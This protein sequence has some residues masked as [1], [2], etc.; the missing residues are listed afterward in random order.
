MRGDAVTPEFAKDWVACLAELKPI[1]KNR[2]MKVDGRERYKFADLDAALAYVVPVLARHNLVQD[3]E[4]D[5]TGRCFTTFTH[6]S[7]EQYVRGGVRVIIK[8]D[9]PQSQGSAFSYA[10]RYSLLPALGIATEDDDGKAAAPD[11]A[12]PRTRKAAPARNEPPPHVDEHG[13]IHGPTISDKQM[14]RL[15]AIYGALGIKDAAVQKRVTGLI[16]NRPPIDTHSTLNPDEASTVIDRLAAVEAGFLEFE[17]DDQTNVVGVRD[18]IPPE[19]AS[20]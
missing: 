13:E 14:R 1:R 5:E 9:D 20:D 19:V 3:Q 18:A 17:L 16:L 12:T 10:R 4:F 11:A 7:G 15:R 6:T 2:S 8:R